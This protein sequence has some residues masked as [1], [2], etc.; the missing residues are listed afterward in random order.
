MSATW[1]TL[2]LLEWGTSIGR[3]FYGKGANVMLGPGL[4][5]ARIPRNGRKIEYLSGED[6]T[7]GAL[8]VPS[9]I[10]GIQSNRVV[11]NVKHWVLNSQESNRHGVSE[12]ASERAKWELYY[13]PF[14]AAVDA[15]VGSVMCSYNRVD[16]LYSCANA[17][18]HIRYAAN[19]V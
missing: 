12:E 16:S 1:D 2:A 6:P 3:E 9:A 8:L 14:A 13:P 7:L 11:A 10:R 15:G 5:V 18:S 17:A 19:A 4:C